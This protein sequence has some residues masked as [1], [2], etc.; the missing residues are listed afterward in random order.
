MS[1][2]FTDPVTVPVQKLSFMNEIQLAYSERRQALGQSA[3][4]AFSEGAR[5]QKLSTWHNWQDWLEANCTSFVNHSVNGGVFDGQDEITM[6]TLATFRSVA[7]LHADG[8]RRLP[9]NATEYTHGV[10]QAGDR[11]APGVIEDIQKGFAALKWTRPTPTNTVETNHGHGSY[12]TSEYDPEFYPVPPYDPSVLIPAKTWEEARVDAEASFS[13][14]GPGN[15]SMFT[16]GG[17]YVYSPAGNVWRVSVGATY[18]S[19]RWKYSTSPASHVPRSVEYYLFPTDTGIEEGFSFDD[20]GTGV[21]FEKYKLIETIAETE[22]ESVG[23]VD[24]FG[25][26]SLPAMIS[27]PETGREKYTD[28]YKWESRGFRTSASAARAIVKWNFTN[29]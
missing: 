14:V 5:V 26:L 8:F 21:V 22:S 16:N 4:S 13:D 19:S 28:Y 1:A 15:L 25:S 7:G 24:W 20:N 18:Y 17:C 10:A 23:M 11:I 3:A 29:A 12:L 27:N 6:F 2:A 9:H